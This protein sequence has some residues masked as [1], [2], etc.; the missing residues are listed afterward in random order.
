VCQQG[1]KHRPPVLCSLRGVSIW[2]SWAP[3][4]RR[5]LAD[6]LRRVSRHQRS[7]GIGLPSPLGGFPVFVQRIQPGVFHPSGDGDIGFFSSSTVSSHHYNITNDKRLDQNALARGTPPSKT[8]GKPHHSRHISH[9]PLPPHIAIASATSLL[10]CFIRDLLHTHSL[11]PRY[12]VELH[13]S[14]RQISHE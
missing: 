14:C 6:Q 11:F 1:K 10:F 12:H 13:I 4:T 7:R 5:S 2:S 8:F 9:K 3:S